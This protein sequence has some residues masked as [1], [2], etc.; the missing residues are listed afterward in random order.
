MTCALAFLIASLVLRGALASLYPTSPV[1]DTVYDAG[2]QNLVAWTDD[3]PK[4]HLHEISALR[5]DL[6][7]DNDV[8]LSGLSR[9]LRW[10]TRHPGFCCHVG[11]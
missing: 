10:L 2:R 4:P 5:I 6:Y 3:S 1:V 8:R 9:L 11:D 7:Q